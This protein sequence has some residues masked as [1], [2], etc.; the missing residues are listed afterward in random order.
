MPDHSPTISV[1]IPTYNGASHIADALRSVLRQHQPPSEILIC[2]DR[3][4]DETLS[5][6]RDEAGDR[7]R[8]LVNS[9]RLGLAANWNQCVT[10]ARSPLVAVFHQDDVMHP[11]HLHLHRQALQQHPNLGFSFSAFDVIDTHSL[12]VPSSQID[13]PTL[14]PMPHLFPPGAFLR[15]LASQ[16]PVRCSTVVLNRDAH[17]SCGGFDPAYRYAVDWEFWARVGRSWP[18]FWIPDPSVS[19]RW[20][21]AS[22]TQRFRRGTADLDE[23]AALL[24]HLHQ[25]EHPP[26]PDSARLRSSARSRLARAYL[27]RAYTALK[28]GH[29]RLARNCLRQVWQLS[30]VLALRALAD[31][32]LTGLFLL[33]TLGL[34]SRPGP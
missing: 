33:S 15:E 1:A 7:A 14:G 32:R 3:S 27:N 10:C 9:E 25:S 12:P 30:P 4:D 6:I 20:H 11:D 2:D 22:E 13:T 34:R 24:T 5:L 17:S 19:V 29:N 21:P 8:I 16:N 26:W 18:V 23:V 28:G 31:P